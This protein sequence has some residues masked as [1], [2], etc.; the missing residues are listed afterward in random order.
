VGAFALIAA[1]MAVLAPAALAA[2]QPRE[3]DPP[4][5]AIHSDG[6]RFATFDHGSVVRVVDTRD[7]RSFFVKVPDNCF[8][9]AV[10]GGQL[11]FQCETSPAPESPYEPRQLPLLYSIKRAAFHW[12]A[13]VE[14]LF[15]RQGQPSADGSRFQVR[16]TGVGRHWIALD[17][18]T[19]RTAER[20]L[21][22]W[23]GGSW[24]TRASKE[25]ARNVIDLDAPEAVTT[26]CSPLR[27]DG[28]ALYEPFPGETERFAE[29]A[30]APPF[31][32]GSDFGD[33]A[34]IHLARCG[35]GELRRL[36]R[37][38]VERGL[39]PRV[40]YW[41]VGDRLHVLNLRSGARAAYDFPTDYMEIV[42]TTRRLYVADNS[43]AYV[44]RTP[45]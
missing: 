16:Y 25:R 30:Y 35:S 29:Y 17:E 18:A 7:G 45:R 2:P 13:R 43:A 14:T 1:L 11:L 44:L 31:G 33:R 28:D 8:H 26:L 12:P 36:S 3:L 10:G 20:Y 21:Y 38:A 40:A 9:A 5:L 22:E 41:Q 27:R 15:G 39:T 24:G 23:H 6:V 19:G 37:R 32:L 42:G 34:L 4:P